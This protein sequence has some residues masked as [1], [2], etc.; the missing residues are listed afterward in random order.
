MNEAG[1]SVGMAAL[2]LVVLAAGCTSATVVPEG[3]PSPSAA[4]QVR[5]PGAGRPAD[6]GGRDA[7]SAPAGEAGS[8]VP[9]DRAP[10]PVW[11]E[12]P[13]LGPAPDTSANAETSEAAVRGYPAAYTVEAS[14]AD[15]RPQ[16]HHPWLHPAAPGRT[17]GVWTQ[18]PRS[19]GVTRRVEVLELELAASTGHGDA[20]ERTGHVTTRQERRTWLVFTEIVDLQ[21]VPH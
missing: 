4:K 20:W 12:E 21:P 3:E 1:S 13:A 17:G 2:S 5:H 9:T 19:D 15:I 6:P 10:E 14:D 18:D 7:G 11:V 16:R 8:D